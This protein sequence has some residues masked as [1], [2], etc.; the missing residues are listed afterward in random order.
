MLDPFAGLNTT[1]AVA[2]ELGRRWLAIEKDEDYATDPQLRFH[3]PLRETERRRRSHFSL[4]LLSW[5]DPRR[6]HVAKDIL[7]YAAYV[8]V[9]I[10]ICIVQ[11]LPLEMG[12]RL[13]A[14]AAWLMHDVLRMRAKVIDENLAH[15]FRGS[16]PE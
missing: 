15:A 7:D 5:P 1:G 13:A 16:G 12:R 10:L 9:R 8:A 11:A 3:I 14:A 4:I 2:E 6:D